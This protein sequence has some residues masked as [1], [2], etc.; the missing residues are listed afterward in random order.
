MCVLSAAVDTRRT[1]VINSVS[2]V[3]LIFIWSTAR[4][5]RWRRVGD[6]ESKPL[7]NEGSRLRANNS[8]STRFIPRGRKPAFRPSRVFAYLF[9]I[10]S[11]L[12]SFLER[13]PF[14]FFFFFLRLHSVDCEFENKSYVHA[15]II[16]SV[17]NF[18]FGLFSA[19]RC[20]YSTS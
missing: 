14:L 8:I 18:F 13:C 5:R 9:P 7:K 15:K 12:C 20:V 10:P 19:N 1:I 4:E 6:A 17:R 11:L 3:P 2:R 16:A